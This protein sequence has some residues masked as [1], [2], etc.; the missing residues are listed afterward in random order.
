MGV[1]SVGE[2]EMRWKHRSEAEKALVAP[3]KITSSSDVYEYMKKVMADHLEV[4][5]AMYA[6][7]TNRANLVMGRVTLG[8]GTVIAT[9]LNEAK[10]LQAMILLN[11]SGVILAHNHPSGSLSPSIGDKAC[12]I[13]VKEMLEKFKLTLLD[14]LII[15]PDSYYSF[16]DEG[17][18]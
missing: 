17:L 14:H 5:E 13:A 18:L 4:H 15:T 2:I 12:T 3:C 16:A 10:L 7:I 8:E 9:P 11:A 1:C 6:L